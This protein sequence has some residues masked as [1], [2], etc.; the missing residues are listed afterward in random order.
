MEAQ[1]KILALIIWMAL[2]I[3]L[4]P[5]LHADGP[6]KGYAQQRQQM[7]ETQIRA[8]GVTDPAVLAAMARVPRHLFVPERMRPLAYLDRPLPIGHG[9]TISQPYIVALMSALLELEPGGRVLEVGTGSGYQAAVL[10]AMGVGVYTIEIVPELGRQAEASLAA[11]GYG[12]VRVK[13]GDGYKG[14]PAHAP[15]DGIIVTCAPER[16]PDPLKAQLA[17]GGR[18][19]IPVGRAGGVQELV[20][21]RRVEG[22]IEQ[23]KI[24]DVR[25]VPMVDERGE[26]Y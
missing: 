17:E 15:F 12:G 22:R 14:W 10:A 1:S 21:L 9:Q 19:V 5:D 16:I 26:N 7:V 8:R 6:A 20:L 25:F 18:M 2:V 11:A 4:T 13:V 24:I 23:Q 3:D